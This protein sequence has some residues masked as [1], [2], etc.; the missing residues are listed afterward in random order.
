MGKVIEMF[1]DRFY[2][3]T[4]MGDAI[5]KSKKEI[6]DMINKGIIIGVLPVSSNRWVIQQVNIIEL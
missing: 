1:P 3:A 6:I 5:G 4:Q 2:T